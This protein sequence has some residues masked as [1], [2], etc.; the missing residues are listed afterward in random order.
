[1]PVTQE[2]VLL[3]PRVEEFLTYCGARNL[4]PNTI[5]AYRADLAEFV[6]LSGGSEITSSQV[7]RKLIR[8]LMVRLYESG[9]K[10]SSIQ[11]KLAAVKSF[12]KCLNSEGLIESSLI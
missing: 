9:A 4:S 5:R 11:R 8:S 2:P 1:M 3:Q 12:C 6:V 7:N 10:R